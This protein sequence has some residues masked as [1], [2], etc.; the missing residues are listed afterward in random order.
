MK[1][2]L[3]L[4]AAFVLSAT[5][6]HGQGG[7]LAAW[8]R[9]RTATARTPGLVRYYT[10]EGED[11]DSRFANRAVIPAPLEYQLPGGGAVEPLTWVDGRWPGKS[12]ARLDHGRLEAEPP[13]ISTGFT[14]EAW[15]RTNGCGFHRGNNGNTDGTLLS[16]GNG[17]WDGMRLSTTYPDRTLTLEI[18]RPQPSTSVGVVSAQARPDGVWQHV[19]ATWDGATMRI[20]IDGLLSASAPYSGRFTNPLSDRRLRIGFADAGRGS[21]KLDVDEVAWYTRALPGDEIARHAHFWFDMPERVAVLMR[22]GGERAVARKWSEG[23]SSFRELLSAPELDPEVAAAGRLGLAR[24]LA[25]RGANREAVAELQ[26]VADGAKISP[27]R[28]RVAMEMLLVMLPSS[29]GEA[30]R[31]ALLEALL[32]LPGIEPSARHDV[33]IALA[34]AATAARSPRWD[35]LYGAALSACAPNSRQAWDTMLER[36]NAA[37]FLGKVGAAAVGFRSLASAGSYP[38]TYRAIAR[39]RLAECSIRQRQWQAARLELK[40]VAG[41]ADV[42]RHLAWEADRR[43]AEVARLASGLPAR[44]PGASRFPLRLPAPGRVVWVSPRGN[45]TNPGTSSRPLATLAGARD[46]VRNLI[47]AGLPRGGIE[48]RLGGGQYRLAQT[49]A[50]RREDSGVPGRP[51]VY[52]AAPGQV[53]RVTGGSRLPAPSLVTA[54]EVLARLDPE[55]R[56][57]VC[58]VDLKAAGLEDPGEVGPGQ[59]RSTLYW[60]GAPLP[61]SRWPNQGYVR[62]GEVLGTR[63]FDVWG[64]PGCYDGVFRYEGDRALR[65]RDEKEAW[66]YGYWFWDWADG[67]QRVARIDTAE[68]VITLAEPF[69]SYGFRKDQRYCVLN[70]LS[71]IDMPGEWCIDRA[72]GRLYVYPPSSPARA[73]I[74]LSRLPGSLVTLDEVS[75]VAFVGLTLDCGRGN[76]ISIKGG[77]S[78][79]LAGC[80]IQRLGGEGVVIDGGYGHQVLSCDIRTLGRGGIKANAGDRKRLVSGRLV[81]DN[82]HIHDFSRIDRTYTPAVYMDGVGSRISHNLMNDSPHHAIRL[83]GNDHLLE[84]NEIHSVVYDADDQAGLD[85]WYNAAYRGNVVRW[86]YWHHIGS[87]LHSNGQA[88]IRLDDAICGVLMY[89]NVFYR[90]A[91]GGFGAI[92]IHGGKENV[93]DGNLFVSCDPVVSFSAWGAARWKD[94]VGTQMH[95]LLHEDIEI[96]EPP[97]STRYPELAK[98]LEGNDRNALWRNVAAGCGPF[99]ARDPGTEDLV[100]NIT[101]GG[102]PSTSPMPALRPGSLAEVLSGMAPIPY[103]E[104]GLYR[105]PLRRQWPVLAPVSPHYLGPR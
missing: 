72:T 66:L 62:T 48:V 70:C 44:D 100:G 12:G 37:L 92:Q 78:V 7:T 79:Q 69:H 65:W 63:K 40:A 88:G 54:P 57:K 4:V 33:L 58:E 36:A 80:T 59:N 95:K 105:D 60:N 96:S 53:P 51:V 49:F 81:I 85:M 87:G 19:A 15:I 61:L 43:L 6:C 55:V 93:V 50:L 20:Y 99:L 10:F 26:A 17:Y 8:Q 76:G 3:P 22:V 23:E 1:L 84:F 89:G 47:A 32:K 75:N 103:G 16:I 101:T 13:A 9:Y 35:R 30:I 2:R 31:P 94:V 27:S 98:L 64:M 52:R 82:C 68:R 45:D 39:L 34:R 71:E 97:Y 74:E 24:C 29:G 11:A 77:R 41:I 56:G 21:A 28:R 46:R 38:A 90:S 5:V 67:Y 14:V 25:G 83:E 18:G 91:G 42:P 86:N 102:R 104:I 73:T